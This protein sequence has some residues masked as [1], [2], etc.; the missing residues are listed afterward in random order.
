MNFL[1]SLLLMCNQLRWSNVKGMKGELTAWIFAGR[2][3]LVSPAHRGSWQ[4]GQVHSIQ[5]TEGSSCN[6]YYKSFVIVRGI[7]LTQRL[8]LWIVQ[9]DLRHA[10]SIQNMP[11]ILL[12]W[13]WHNQIGRLRIIPSRTETERLHTN[14]TKNNWFHWLVEACRILS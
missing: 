9:Q 10:G 14:S 2:W 13:W 8:S 1:S 12:I 4:S 3:L 7:K 6:I 5:G 11:N